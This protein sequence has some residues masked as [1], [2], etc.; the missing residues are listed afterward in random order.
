MIVACVIRRVRSGRRKGAVVTDWAHGVDTQTP[1]AA[2]MYDYYL[3]GSHNFAADRAAADKVIE[4]IPDLPRIA[5]A[6]R[7]FLGR[8]VRFIVE[9]GVNQFLDIGSGIPTLGNVHEVAEQADPQAR[10]VYVD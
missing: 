6:N 4:A 10:V 7:A 5:Q 2:R 3:G 8:A 9:A 1:S